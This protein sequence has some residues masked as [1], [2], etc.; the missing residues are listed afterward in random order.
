MS[1]II[2]YF[3]RE[4]NNYVNGSIVNLKTGNTETAA[5]FIHELTGAPLAKLEPVKA[6]ALDY[7]ECIKEAQQE[8]RT[9]ARPAVKALPDI[10]GYDT[11]YLGYPNWWGTCPMCLF[12]FIESQNWAGKTVKP[13]CTHEGSGMGHSEADLKKACAGANVKKGLALHGADVSKSK[14][15]IQD[16]ID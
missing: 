6:Y 16:W 5:K 14:A 7:N 13:F 10:S 1:A 3:S 15:Q 4:G 8:Q 9:N 2:V 12:T 11:I